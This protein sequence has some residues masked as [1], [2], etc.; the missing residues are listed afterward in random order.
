VKQAKSINVQ[1]LAARFLIGKADVAVILIEPLRATSLNVKLS[2]QAG[3]GEKVR[4]G[5][6]RL[7]VQSVAQA[8]IVLREVAKT[9]RSAKVVE[10]GLMLR[11][12]VEDVSD[13]VVECIR[14]IVYR[15]GNVVRMLDVSSKLQAVAR[16]VTELM[17]WM[18]RSGALQDLNREYAELRASGSA[19]EY[20]TWLSARVEERL[21]K[22]A[23]SS[24]MY[25]QLE[26]SSHHFVWL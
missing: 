6:K 8:E 13:R 26:V 10:D 1:R 11:G 25:A 19:P 20:W 17:A 5:G 16:Y 4:A 9:E 21:W 3:L 18:A 14:R 23:A 22:A 24:P 7:V 2:I 15:K 12:A